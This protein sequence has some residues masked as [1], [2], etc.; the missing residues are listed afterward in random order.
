[1]EGDQQSCS[2]GQQ[3]RSPDALLPPLLLLGEEQGAGRQEELGST[4][5]CYLQL[6]DLGLPPRPDSLTV[7]TAT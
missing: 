1:M 2:Q 5:A 3:L 4:P 7:K 6:R